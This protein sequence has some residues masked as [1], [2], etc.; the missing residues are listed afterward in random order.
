MKKKQA[1][2]LFVLPSLI[3]VLAFYLLPFLDVMRRS[4]QKA[5]GGFCGLE[6]YKTVWNN[7]AFRLAAINTVRFVAVCIPLLLL[8]AL[9]LALVLQRES[10]FGVFFKSAYL[11]PLAIPAASVVLLWRVLFDANGMVNGVLRMAGG[12]GGDWMNSDHAFYVLV[13]SYIWKNLGYVVVLWIAALSGI[14][15]SIYEAAKIDGAGRVATFFY[16]TLPCMRPAAFTIVVVSFLNSF[17]VFREAYLVAGNYPQERIYLLQHVFNNW[18]INLSVDKMAAGTVMLAVVVSVL[19]GILQ[20]MW[21][22]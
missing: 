4:F 15:E 16:V 10:R 1:G 7:E 20:R 12:G 13:G 8:L 2:I 14:A 21:E 3:G 11:V 18:F 17:K 9:L 5:V 19:V 22:R 6:N